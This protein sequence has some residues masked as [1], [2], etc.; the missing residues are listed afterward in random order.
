MYVHQRAAAQLSP[1]RHGVIVVVG[2]AAVALGVACGG[3]GDDR[4]SA[5]AAPAPSDQ[6]VAQP[7]QA[8]APPIEESAPVEPSAQADASAPV[9][10]PAPIEEAPPQ[11]AT[12]ATPPVALPIEETRGVD[13]TST[14]FVNIF[15]PQDAGPWPVVLVIPGGGGLPSATEPFAEALAAQGAVVFNVKWRAV[16][17]RFRDAA[18]DVACAVRFA[19]ATAA[20]YG[21]DST[22]ITLLGHSRGGAIGAVVALAGEDFTGDCLVSGGSALPDVFIGV[23]GGYD[24]AV[25][26][27]AAFLK[28]EDAELWA[29]INPYTHVGRNAEVQVRLVHGDM[30]NVV[31]VDEAIH[32]EQAL[33]A[34]GYDVT[35][36]V[37]EG[38]THNIV[39]DPASE[40]GDVTL[41]TTLATAHE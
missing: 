6:S 33:T 18:E 11:Q 30:D 13:Y 39:I 29:S 22:R 1:L 28:D 23:A 34:A 16:F 37:L 8:E 20:S 9:G 36:V 7:V 21:G 14:Q 10:E 17:P 24:F 27:D 38:A 19:R 12:V 31:M 26:G 2:L 32:F 4:S 35:L 41:Q 3:G 5:P 15:A 25:D 40:P